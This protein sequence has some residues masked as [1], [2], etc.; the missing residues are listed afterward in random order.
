MAVARALARRPAALLLDEPLSALDPRLRAAG[1]RELA[2]VLAET[3]VP[4]LLVTHDFTEA[5]VLGTRVGVIDA[6]RIIQQ[7]TAAELAASPASAFV[8]DFTGAVVLTGT[9]RAA[10]HGLTQVM[11]DGGGTVYSLEPREGP[12]AVSVYPWEIALAPPDSRPTGSAQ[13]H[14]PVRVVS[15]T[16][17][18]NRVRVGLVAPQPLTAELSD[19]SAQALDL[20]PQAFRDRHLES[21]RHPPATDLTPEPPRGAT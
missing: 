10:D 17:V 21:S 18:A 5:A 11:L 7:G 2:A 19:A 20:R 1:G 3:G 13:N 14:L 16:A 12:V 8:A 15:V 4:A 6:G 9:A